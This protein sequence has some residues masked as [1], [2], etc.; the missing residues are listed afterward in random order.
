MR[1][2]TLTAGGV[3]VLALAL[4]LTFTF[5]P[6]TALRIPGLVPARDALRA[7][8]P[9]Q[10]L[11]GLGAVLSLYAVGASWLGGGRT[12]PTSGAESRYVS[13]REQPPERVVDD[14]RTP[15]G[16]TVDADLNASEVSEYGAADARALLYETAHATLAVTTD[17]PER[18]LATGSWTDDQRAAAFLSG[19]DDVDH[20][21]W[22]RLRFWL[23]PRRE[24]AR[25]VRAAAREVEALGDTVSEGDAR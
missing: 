10:L 4:G 24:R 3:G 14:G 16:D 9:G 25:R 11:T 7:V 20:T 6:E 8:S 19:T 23:D 22:S 13:V 12:S 18:A 1:F 2:R 5:A 21:V 15:V 17:D